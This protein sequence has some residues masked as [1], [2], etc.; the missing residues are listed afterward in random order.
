MVWRLTKFPPAPRPGHD[1]N[2]YDKR[3]WFFFKKAVSEM[4]T[5]SDRVLDLGFVVD[6]NGTCRKGRKFFDEYD[7]CGGWVAAEDDPEAEGL[8]TVVKACTR[9]RQF[10]RSLEVFNGNLDGCTFTNGSVLVASSCTCQDL[11]IALV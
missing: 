3:G 6:D 9:G 10:P 7:G 11:C 2:P 4:I 5:P 8:P 1:I